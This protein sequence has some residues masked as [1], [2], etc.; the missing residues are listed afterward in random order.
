MVECRPARTR[1]TVRL[2]RRLAAGG[3]RYCGWQRAPGRAAGAVQRGQRR[4]RWRACA[5]RV[6][7]G[8]VF[9]RGDL[10]A[11]RQRRGGAGHRQRQ[12]HR[13]RQPAAGRSCAGAR[14]AGRPARFR[15]ARHR[16]GHPG[17]CRSAGQG[18]LEGQRAAP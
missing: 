5:D 6:D 15:L 8:P 2:L 11:L 14:R 18:R 7:Q 12:D 10:P 3:G 1:R 16:S 17:L 9:A 4:T 13:D